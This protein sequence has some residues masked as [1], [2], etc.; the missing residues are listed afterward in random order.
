MQVLKGSVDAGAGDSCPDRNLAFRFAGSAMYAMP[1]T[2]ATARA[3]SANFFISVSF[4]NAEAVVSTCK[5]SPY[6]FGGG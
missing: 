5:S 1:N 2:T 4:Q 6:R 3:D